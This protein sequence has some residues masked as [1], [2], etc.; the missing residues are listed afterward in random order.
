[1]SSQE[2]ETTLI[3]GAMRERTGGALDVLRAEEERLLACVHC[4][5]C[6]NACPTYTRLGDEADSPRGR[7]VL[8]RAVAE[9]RLA[10]D[11]DAFAHHID[12]C[13]GCRACET[14]CPS[15]VEYGFLLERA[16]TVIAA[17]QG[18]GFL[19]K[20]LLA[21]FANRSASFVSSGM[22]RLLRA[23]GLAGTLAR[24]TP[25]RFGTVRTGLAMI[26]ATRPWPA[27]QRGSSGGG[28]AGRQPV[29]SGP[30]QSTA[31]GQPGG[32]DAGDDAPA[33]DNYEYADPHA[34]F[35]EVPTGTGMGVMMEAGDVSMKQQVRVAFLRGCVQDGLF[36]RV[37][38]ATLRVL[39]ANGCEVVDVPEQACCGALHAHSGELERAHD[40]A[41]RNIEA[42]DAAGVD[43]IIVNAAGCG[44]MMK[45]YGAQ[46][47][48]DTEWAARAGRVATRVRDIF[49]F[50]VERGV[51]TGAP[52]PLRVT[53]DA[54][55][56]LH[57]GQR[58]TR[59]PLDVLAS[60]PGVELIPLDDSEEC[61]GGA[62][63]YGIQHPDLGGRIVN[64]KLDAIARTGAEVVVTGNPGCIMQI[65][66]GLVL[67]GDDR[68]VLHPIELLDESYRRA[69]DMNEQD[70]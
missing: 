30:V 14:V 8:M 34:R 65:G 38:D 58:I 40:L 12:Q 47:E 11:S 22:S 24:L 51:R 36:G 53:Y 9:G 69:G 4:G 18:T 44:A 55:C 13:L 49:E 41:R 50:L 31:L 68:P 52:L 23:G 17:E 46:L 67:R 15:G 64:D 2:A 42:F 5:F 6:L 57:H 62:G 56:H 33:A 37:N 39:R 43:Y 27:L 61:C 70:R 16:R 7:L 20:M 28:S 32:P 63:I 54:P 3:T 48:R 1:M 35:G 29:S 25:K 66:A 60:I 26:A 19:S 59:A 10:A 21:G 45:E